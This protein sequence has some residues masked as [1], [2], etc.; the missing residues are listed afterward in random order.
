MGVA[1]DQRAFWNG[2]AGAQ[3]VTDQVERDAMLVRF[4][5]AAI[6]ASAV[7]AGEAVLDVGCGCGTTT[8]ALADAVGPKGRVVGLDISAPMLARA[9]AG[10]GAHTNVAFELGDA[11]A[12]A[13]PPAAFDLLFSRFGVMFFADP[14]GSFTHLAKTLRPGGRLAFVCWRPIAENPWAHLPLELAIREVGAPPPADPEAPGPFAFADPA[15]VRRLLEAS[16]FASVEVSPFDTSTVYGA[17][18]ALAA[19]RLATMGPAMRLLAKKDDAAATARAI[20]ALEEALGAHATDAGV[21][22][23]GAAWIVTARRA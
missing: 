23:S 10:R 8:F 5:E 2:D 17:T 1:E 18:P 13:Q 22:L 4:G 21:A 6:R 15:R 11:G 14:V 9:H 3:W 20:A 16:G 19:V 7:A 12:V